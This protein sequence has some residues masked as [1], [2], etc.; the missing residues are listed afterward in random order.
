MSFFIRSYTVISASHVNM[1]NENHVLR[2]P[3]KI[4]GLFGKK[5]RLPKN[6]IS[7]LVMTGT[8]HLIPPEGRK[9]LIFY[10]WPHPVFSIFRTGLKINYYRP[11]V[12]MALL[13]TA[14]TGFALGTKKPSILWPKVKINIFFDFF[15][16]PSLR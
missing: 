14:A 8:I 13:F 7:C 15:Y 16:R 10:L 11:E 3:R 9:T 5:K 1:K 12:R 2:S 6:K 4:L